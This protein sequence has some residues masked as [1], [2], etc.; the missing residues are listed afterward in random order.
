MNQTISGG[1]TPAAALDRLCAAD[2]QPYIGKDFSIRFS[3]G[4]TETAQLENVLEL[5]GY[6]GLERKPFSIVFQT[7]QQ[8]TYYLQ[9]IYSVEH[10]AFGALLI[11]LVP[12]GIKG[13]GM[14][15]EAVFS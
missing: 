9:A 12:L 13:K 1:S 8:T 6:S 3:A 2:F 4:V 10:P 14:Q 11:F 5:T 15:Y 7:A